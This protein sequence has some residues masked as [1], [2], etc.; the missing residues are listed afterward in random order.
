MGSQVLLGPHQSHS[1]KGLSNI[2]CCLCL[3]KVFVLVLIYAAVGIKK[4][5]SLNKSKLVL[6]F[7]YYVSDI[8]CK[9]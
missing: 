4:R 3:N 8:F 1:F 5:V 2:L 7:S 6:W 9:F